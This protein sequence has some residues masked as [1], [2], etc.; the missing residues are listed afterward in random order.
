MVTSGFSLYLKC[1]FSRSTVFSF[2][3]FLMLGV[4]LLCV[5]DCCFLT[6]RKYLQVV[7]SKCFLCPVLSLF[8]QM[9]LLMHAW[10]FLP[11]IR[12]LLISQNLCVLPWVIISLCIHSLLLLL[13]TYAN[14]SDELSIIMV[15]FSSLILISFVVYC[16]YFVDEIS[17]IFAEIL[18]HWEH[19]LF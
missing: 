12:T 1:Q 13:C 19:I 11:S 14:F 10:S 7:S 3:Q 4:S 8:L 17:S 5:H 6:S 2:Q 16:I 9:F 18:I 15:I